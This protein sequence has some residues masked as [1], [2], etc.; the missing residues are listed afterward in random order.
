MNQVSL[1]IL[2]IYASSTFQQIAPFVFNETLK[3]TTSIP[4]VI[5]F[6][7]IYLDNLLYILILLFIIYEKVSI[8]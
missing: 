6:F 7:M 3:Y 1:W 2:L 8:E 5:E 4:V